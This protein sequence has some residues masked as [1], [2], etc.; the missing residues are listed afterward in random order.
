MFHYT[1]FNILIEYFV[2]E[3]IDSTNGGVIVG[4]VLYINISGANVEGRIRG[5]WKYNFIIE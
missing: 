1:V 5:G 4:I 2:P 3:V